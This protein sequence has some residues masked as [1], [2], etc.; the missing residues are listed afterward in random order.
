MA[1]AATNGGN[2]TASPDHSESPRK[3]QGP[4]G[5]ERKE[6]AVE[7]TWGPPQ[8]HLRRKGEVIGGAFPGG[9]GVSSM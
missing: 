9:V 1:E 3:D 2:S 6:I 4:K 8:G 7:F 5:K